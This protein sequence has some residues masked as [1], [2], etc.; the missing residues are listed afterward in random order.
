MFRS[1]RWRLILSY[2]LIATLT[3]GVVGIATH[4]LIYS[5]LIQM[6]RRSLREN[7]QAVAQQAYALMWPRTAAS[8]LQQLTRTAAFLGD[9]HVQVRDSQGNV[10]ADSD[11]ADDAEMVFLLQRD[12]QEMWGVRSLPM[13]GPMIMAFGIDEALRLSDPR[14]DLLPAGVTVIERDQ[15]LWGARLTF[16]E[17][18]PVAIEATPAARDEGS[19]HVARSQAAVT[20]P[21]GDAADPIGYVEIS[22][23][24]ALNTTLLD[25]L[26]RSLTL[27]GLGAVV[28]AGLFGLWTSHRMSAPI[29]DL[30]QTAAQMGAGD[31]SVRATAAQHDRDA[32]EIR[33]LASQFN[34]MADS[35]EATFDPLA[36]ERD[37]LRRFI[38]DASHELRTPITALSN[39]NSLL[40]DG[41]AE[42]A[43]TRDEFLTESQ[44]QIARL[45]WITNHLLD[46]SR[47]DAGLT[48]PERTKHDL[49]DI[50]HSAVATLRPRADEKALT[51]TVDLPDAPLPLACD[52]AQIEIALTNLLDNALKYTPSGGAVTVA[53]APAL[54]A[55]RP[56]VAPGAS[57]IPASQPGVDAETALILTVADTGIGIDPADLPR[58]FDRFYR[59]QNV[60]T[61]DG[62]GLGLAIVKSIVDAHGGAVE[63]ESAPGEGTTATVHL[64]RRLARA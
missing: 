28:I 38:A 48:A 25:Q 11:A 55:T 36:A 21:I 43:E 1:I 33:E 34:Q 31:L 58:V 63:L 49:R 16:K 10:L 59:G 40:L 52:R 17:V 26:Q 7:A 51:L 3:V 6:E 19:A 4:R 37:A 24:P 9:V 5:S 29:R 30:A 39:F 47:R 62:A 41:A 2:M 42:N 20:V 54:P 22:E 53:A 15:G 14:G 56:E 18:W 27:A 61:E 13:R 8:E 23:P 45:T 32:H 46:L 57:A 35:L 44:A 64:P 60:R 12:A 50:V